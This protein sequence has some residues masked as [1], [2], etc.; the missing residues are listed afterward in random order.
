MALHIKNLLKQLPF[1]GKTIKPRIKEF[2]NAK[3]LSELPFFEKPIKA[4]IKQLNTKKLLQEQPFY[5]QS[6]K[7][8]RIKKLKKYELLRELQ[9]YHD[10]NI[11]R[12]ERAFRRHA[13]NYRA[14]VINN[15]SLS[16]SLSVSKN[17]TKNLFDELLRDEHKYSTVYFNSLVKTVINQRYHLNDSFEEILNLLDIWINESSAWTIA[18]IDG[19][20][21]NTSNY[22][23]LLGAS[24]IPLPKVLNNSMKG[25][26]NLK[27]NNH[28][29]FMWCHVRLID[30]TNSHPQRT[31]KQDKK[32]AANLNYSNIVFPLDINDYEKI[33]DRF[34]MFW[35]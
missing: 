22:E 32:V 35:L 17:S 23:P 34:Q 1:Y 3:L 27:N 9:F 21:I 14:E 16:D 2:T 15:K 18:Q 10:I 5:K 11:S 24:Y 4:K 25:L 30:T 19:L 29:C 7:K 6:I 12:K 33:E 13:E 8:P 26:I 20:Y 31:N 28:K